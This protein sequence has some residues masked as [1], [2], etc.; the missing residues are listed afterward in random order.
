MDN[1]HTVQP[2]Q[3]RDALYAL[4]LAVRLP[5]RNHVVVA[6]VSVS[7]F[8]PHRDGADFTLRVCMPDGRSKTGRAEV[9]TK[10]KDVWM[11]NRTYRLTSEFA[12]TV[13]QAIVKNLNLP[14]KGTKSDGQV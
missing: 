6:G 3:I 9:Y 2:E 10:S 12:A 11:K 4:R 7:L 13:A 8:W 1:K 5:E 14:P